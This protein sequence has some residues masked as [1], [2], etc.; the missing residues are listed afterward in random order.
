MQQALYA[1]FELHTFKG[2]LAPLR[3]FQ[4]HSQSRGNRTTFVG[5]DAASGSDRKV[6][7]DF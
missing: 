6:S 3:P 5:R 7:N 1:D 4:E 2:G